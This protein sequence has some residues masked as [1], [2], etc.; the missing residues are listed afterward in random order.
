VP[1][2]IQQRQLDT[3]VTM[4]RSFLDKFKNTV[5]LEALRE[6]RTVQEIAAKN[7]IHQNQNHFFPK[8]YDYFSD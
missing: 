4:R 8:A 3:Q 6:D 5:T 1:R 2:C 7:K